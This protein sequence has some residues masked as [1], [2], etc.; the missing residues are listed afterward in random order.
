[1]GE[2]FPLGGTHAH[3]VDIRVITATNKNPEELIKEGLFREDLYYRLNVIELRLPPLRERKED[4][5]LL[6]N[7]FVK[8]FCLENNRPP[9]SISDEALEQLKRYHWPGNIR[10]LRNVLE[11]AVILS[12]AECITPEDLPEKIR[13]SQLSSSM[14]LKDRL[15]HYER[16]IILECLRNHGGNK[17]EAARELGIDLATLYRKMKRLNIQ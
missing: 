4:I 3:S 11:R 12:T 7:H 9:L 6:A 16:K 13:N 15:S 17:E 5:P 1:T 10:E 8:R 2:V 14:T